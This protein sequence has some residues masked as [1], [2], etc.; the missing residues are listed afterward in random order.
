[1]S[2]RFIAEYG[3]VPPRVVVEYD[4]ATGYMLNLTIDYN[5]RWM[6]KYAS[7]IRIGC[8]FRA[9]HCPPFIVAICRNRALTTLALKNAVS[10]DLVNAGIFADRSYNFREDLTTEEILNKGK[11]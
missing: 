9:W 4:K 2:T 1:M 6:K 7:H 8:L 10:D 3:G 5:R 11:V